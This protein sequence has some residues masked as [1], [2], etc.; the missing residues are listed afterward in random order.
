MSDEMREA[1]GGGLKDRIASFGGRVRSMSKPAIILI[2]TTLLVGIALTAWLVHG[3]VSEPYAVLFGKLSAEDAA[4]VTQKLKEMKAPYKV[5]DGGSIEV[6]ESRVHELRLDIA[7]AGLPRGGG[8]GFESFDKMRL[9]ATEFEQQ[10]MFRRAM[11]GELSRT[12]SSVS[13]VESARVH[14]VQP[15]KSVFVQKREPGSASVVVKL[16]PGRE[17]GQQEISAIVH[18]VG[19][20]VPGLSPD[21]VALA[22]TEGALLRKPKNDKDGKSAGAEDDPSASARELERSMEERVR[23]MLER[24][25]GP[26]HA[27]VRVSAELD[28]AETE[29]TE[30]K[31][32]P[33]AT[34]LRSEELLIERTGDAPADTVAGVPGAE[35]NLP[36]GDADAEIEEVSAA[37][38][39]RRQHTRN[40]EVD[41]VTERRVNRSSTLKRLAVAV[42]V[43]GVSGTDESGAP[44]VSLRDPEELE[45]IEK[46]VRSAV[47]ADDRREDLITVECIPFMAAAPEV[48]DAPVPAAV[49]SPLEKYRPFL[50]HA[51]GGA[52]GLFALM[53]L[54][55]LRRSRKKARAER[56][57]LATV[58]VTPA[59]AQIEGVEIAPLLPPRDEALRRAEEDPATAALI[60]RHWLGGA[61]QE[62]QR[63]AV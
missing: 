33:K 7:G 44:Y 14:L 48:A 38:V 30:D 11:E 24:V 55:M 51:A 59:A 40:F 21:R 34:A 2:A 3:T 41:R 43:D 20:A 26:G 9:G 23:T 5:T 8:V 47:G 15:E 22:T 28:H 13:A 57:R 12:I 27:D 58:T 32:K 42:V 52:L 46:L 63:A 39:V 61:E 25:L 1:T 29:R 19:A 36:T 4:S 49:A 18:L 16:K 62:T 10:V 50:P 45:Q 17:L 35:S 53:G 60:I 6:P 31:F 56:E 54:V 37:G